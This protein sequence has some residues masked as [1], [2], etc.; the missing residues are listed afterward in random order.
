MKKL[1]ALFIFLVIIS[2]SCEVL[3]QISEVNRFAQCD[4]SIRNVQ[5]TKLGE[6]DVSKYKSASDL[7]FTEMLLLGQQLLSSELPAVLSVDI[8]AMNNQTSKAAISGLQWQL[9]MK[10]E[11][12]GGGKLNQYVEVL[13]GH[14]T[15]FPVH[16]EFNLLKLLA[17]ENLQSIINLVFDIENKEKLKKLDIVLKVKPYYK[18]GNSIR[19]YP[20]YLTI[21]P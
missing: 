21:R 8:M 15:N 20:G 6:I 10:D 2:S 1:F 17:S 5:I 14:T 16:V 19:E 11:Q 9:L 7:G 18:Y 3:E 4:F 13:P 12:Y